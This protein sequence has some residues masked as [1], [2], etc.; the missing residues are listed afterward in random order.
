MIDQ[1]WKVGPFVSFVLSL[2]ASCHVILHK[3]DPRAAIGWVGMIW[4]VPI[5]GSLLYF[6]F[7]I[8]RVHRWAR[9]ITRLHLPNP[10]LNSSVVSDDDLSQRIP[11]HPGLVSLSRLVSNLTGKPL[12]KGNSIKPLLNG[13]EAFP[14]MLKA[15]ESAQK[16]ISLSTYIFDNDSIGKEFIRVL[17]GAV[18]RGVAVRVLIDDIGLRYS[19]RSVLKRLKESNIPVARFMG[20]LR[21]MTFPHLNLRKHRK[22]LVVD[23]E[24]A[25]TGGINIREGHVLTAN[26]RHPVSDLHFEIKGEIVKQLQEVF[27]E[28]WV[29]TTRE[30]LKGPKWFGDAISENDSYARVISDGPDEDQFRLAM[31]IEGAI[32]S[33]EESVWILTPYFLPDMGMTRILYITSL[34]SVKVNIL[35]PR[36]NNLA[37]VQW[38]TNPQ[39]LELL[40]HGCRIWYTD[41]PFDHTKLI[42]VDRSWVLFGSANLDPRS[43][44][45][46][47]EMNVECY[48][49]KL[50][51]DL[52]EIIMKK[53]KY[54]HE[55]KADEIK[56]RSLSIKLRDGVAHLFSP[57]M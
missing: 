45:L 7:G 14:H 8:N 34:R 44:R 36:K 29:F 25:F 10:P 53:L 6:L 5:I 30:I 38:A 32:A 54:A 50:S 20:A 13:D 35:L 1:F 17:A 39:L 49:S 15:I 21:P 52:I 19:W 57:Y 2:W 23:G 12:L 26:P 41:P 33:A 48:D 16:S 22:I 9:D 11:E 27:A 37:F 24:V 4:F 28:D 51:S 47:F 46:N 40:N 18:N 55:L 56:N 42:I 31:S 3:K 43:L